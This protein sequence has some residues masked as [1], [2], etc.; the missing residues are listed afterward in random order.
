MRIEED[1]DG[2]AQPILST[3]QLQD[4][5]VHILWECGVESSTKVLNI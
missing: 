1:G 4:Y 3:L 2:T 5:G